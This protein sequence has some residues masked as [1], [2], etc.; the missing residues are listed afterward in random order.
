MKFGRIFFLLLLILLP[1]C[2]GQETVRLPADTTQVPIS[3]STTATAQ[4]TASPSTTATTPATDT[5]SA[6]TANATATLAPTATTAPSPT[7][8]SAPPLESPTVPA[9]TPACP[10]TFLPVGFTGDANHLV[11]LLTV[12]EVTGAWLQILDLQSMTA[13]TL[14]K[15]DGMINAAALSPDGKTAAWA[16][17]DF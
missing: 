7:S 11:G 4:V 17:P 2:S 16:L 12:N 6:A 1:A 13:K 8:T 3:S 5:P 14:R 15:S 9:P 10:A